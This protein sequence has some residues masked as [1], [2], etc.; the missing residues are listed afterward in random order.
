MDARPPRP[1]PVRWVLYAYGRGLPERFRPWV[2]H[3]L[4]T[5]TWQLRQLVRAVV[6]VVPVA[7]LVVLL[8]PGPLWVRAAAVLGGV[9]IGMIY[10]GAYVYEATEHRALKAGYPRGTV[11]AVRD[12]AHAEERA[13]AAKR[14]AA[15]YRGGQEPGSPV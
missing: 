14:Y 5:R 8:V 11:Q 3:D 13:A 4:T 10:A 6:Q 2:L 7:V 1:G 12:A 9:L 15:Q